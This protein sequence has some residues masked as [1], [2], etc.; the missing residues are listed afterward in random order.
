M[1]F[2]FKSQVIRRAESRQQWAPH[3]TN[4]GQSPC[5]ATAGWDPA[6][7]WNLSAPERGKAEGAPI[8]ISVSK[9]D[10]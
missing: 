8:H 4:H 5:S 1:D 3:D 6:Q 7:V 9:R 2:I 10:K